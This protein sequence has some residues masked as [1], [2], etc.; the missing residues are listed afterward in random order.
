MNLPSKLVSVLTMSTLAVALLGGLSSAGAEEMPQC[1]K[2]WV[3]QGR[4]TE[5]N[6]HQIF[7]H[8]SGPEGMPADEAAREAA[9]ECQI[10]QIYANDGAL[11][12]SNIVRYL[13][14]FWLCTT[15]PSAGGR[16]R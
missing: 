5:F 10:A 8:A 6:G 2:D 13:L 12:M 16:S 4:Y 1:I 9:L 15:F 7:V 3:A 14:D 11:V